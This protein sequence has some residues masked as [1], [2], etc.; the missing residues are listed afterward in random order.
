MMKKLFASLL[1]L[2]LLLAGYACAEAAITPTDTLARQAEVDAMLIAEAEAGY[3]LEEPL[4]VV[5]PYGNA[6]LSAI[7]VFTTEQEIG[8]TV[9]ARGR[10][11][12][13]DISGIFAPAT[14][15]FVPI[16]G[17]YAGGITDVEIRLDDGTTAKLQV[18]TEQPELGY[19]GFSAVMSDASLYE[20]NRLNVCCLLTGRMLAGFDSKADLR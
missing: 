16:F 12:E 6:P 8:G 20:Y 3:T 11:P 2:V 19:E 14:T 10:M 15:H 9:T 5:D 4:V 1:M 13:D 18:E 17:L 7:A